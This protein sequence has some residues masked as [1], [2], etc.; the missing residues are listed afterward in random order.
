MIADISKCMPTN[1]SQLLL[2][3]DI[4]VALMYACGRNM[5]TVGFCYKYVIQDSS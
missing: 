5:S 2:N 4:S 3:A 1:R